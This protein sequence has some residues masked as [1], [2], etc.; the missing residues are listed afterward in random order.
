MVLELHQACIDRLKE[1]LKETLPKVELSHGKFLKQPTMLGLF[2]GDDALPKVGAV[3][4]ALKGYI[5][6]YPF[7]DFIYQK[8]SSEVY[9]LSDYIE[10]DRKLSDIPDYMDELA[11]S[12]RLIGEFK[13]LPWKYTFSIELPEALSSLLDPELFTNFLSKSLLLSRV[14]EEFAGKFPL[15]SG[16]KAR[17]ER[18]HGGM[19]LLWGAGDVKWSLGKSCVQ[20]RDEGFVGPYGKTAPVLRAEEALK[21]LLGLCLALGVLKTDH[22]YSPS[23]PKFHFYVHRWSEEDWVIDNKVELESS[24]S[25][26]LSQLKLNDHN[27]SLSPAEQIPWVR[28][29]I[30]SLLICF[31]NGEGQSRVR[32]ASQWLF[33]SYF[34]QNELLSFIQA[35]VALEILLGDKE[36]SDEVGLGTLLRNRCAYLIGKSHAQRREIFSD[37]SDIYHVRSQIVHRGK[38]RLSYKERTMLTKLRWMCSR[39]IE[40]EIDLLKADEKQKQKGQ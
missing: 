32:L 23:R 2:S 12:E 40:E 30:P 9:E 3:R 6:E 14:S 19:S 21:T 38:S 16:L 33:D 29:N 11:L 20:I 39:A 26:G 31:G 22:S 17:D 18:I 10:E 4:E 5:D 24:L 37:F 13:S 8:L 15:T 25:D 28:Y 27:G 35:T 34:G 36:T 1:I 7:Y